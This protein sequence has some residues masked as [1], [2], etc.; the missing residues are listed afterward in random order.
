MI[1]TFD[2]IASFA[3]AANQ[4]ARSNN[5][6]RTRTDGYW[7]GGL[8]FDEALNRCTAGDLSLVSKAEQ[9]LEKIDADV[10]LDRRTWQPSVAGAF[11][12]VPDFLAG[13]PDCM[14]RLL[15]DPSD[16]SP[17][18]VYVSLTGTADVTADQW[19]NRGVAIIALLM[20]LQQVRPVELKILAE[21][22][23][24][25]DGYCYPLITIESRPLDISTAAFALAHAAFC[26]RLC[27]G[28]GLAVDGFSGAC[29]S[30]YGV[31][32]VIRQRLG[33]ADVDLYVAPVNGSTPMLKDPV[34]WVNS[35]VAK[36]S[37][38]QQE[39]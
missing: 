37:T 7:F 16:V 12:C 36:Y 11:P 8:S 27:Y 26:R 6:Y 2:S 30:S 38:V 24:N 20:K 25:S 33:M 3:R 19:L 31:E 14:R 34:A 23:G 21:M 22:H 13:A 15:P 4:A 29:G 32:R 18:S 10:E 35:Q 5:M 28:W 39:A 9:L 17:V 1:C